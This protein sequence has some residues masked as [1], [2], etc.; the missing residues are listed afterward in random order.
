VP[1][2]NLGTRLLLPRRT[3]ALESVED[4]FDCP[5]GEG[6]TLSVP[7]PDEDVGRRGE[8]V[9]AAAFAAQLGAARVGWWNE[10][11]E[12]ALPYDIMLTLPPSS[13]TAAAAAA[14]LS[15]WDHAPHSTETGSPGG[16]EAERHIL[17][18]VKSTSSAQECLAHFS[19]AELEQA[20]QSGANYWVALVFAAASPSPQVRVLRGLTASMDAHELPLFLQFSSAPS[21]SGGSNNAT[22][23]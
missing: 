3:P 6:G 18:E 7:C 10:E 11:Q 12:A 20:Q 19:P 5:A 14:P 22:R 9:V 15:A 4:I 21:L 16:G 1:E 13:V 2:V 17:V 23:G 8:A